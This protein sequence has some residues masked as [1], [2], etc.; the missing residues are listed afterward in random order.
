M[1]VYRGL[2]KNHITFKRTLMWH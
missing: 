2:I 1:F